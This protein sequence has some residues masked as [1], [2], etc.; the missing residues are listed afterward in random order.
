MTEGEALHPYALVREGAN[1]EKSVGVESVTHVTNISASAI[2]G[3]IGNGSSDVDRRAHGGIL[4]VIGRC[5]CGPC[6]STSRHAHDCAVK[7]LLHSPVSF[8]DALSNVVR[9]TRGTK[10]TAST[11]GDCSS[12]RHRLGGVTTV[13]N[14]GISNIV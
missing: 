7:I 2:S 8:S 14:H 11:C 1:E 9:T 3:V 6:T 13:Y 12:P 4:A 5:R 10:C